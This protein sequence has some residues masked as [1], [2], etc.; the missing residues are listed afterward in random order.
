MFNVVN[1]FLPGLLLSPKLTKSMSPLL[2]KSQ[3]SPVSGSPELQPQ[4]C[5]AM[6]GFHMVAGN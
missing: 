1:C 6:P 4:K 5:P 2:S 3:D